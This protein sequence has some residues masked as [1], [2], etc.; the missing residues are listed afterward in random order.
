MESLS[1]VFEELANPDYLGLDDMTSLLA[2]MHWTSDDIPP[3][4]KMTWIYY[5]MGLDGQEAYNQSW[6]GRN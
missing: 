5:H 6:Y 2:R 3:P 1:I 4:S